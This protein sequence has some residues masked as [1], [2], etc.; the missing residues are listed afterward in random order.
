VKRFFTFCLLVCLLIVMIAGIL[1]IPIIGDIENPSYNEVA[2]Y[3]LENSIADTKSPNAVTAVLKYYRG[4][5]T[6][7]ETGV[8]FTSVVAVISVLRGNK[9]SSKKEGG[10]NG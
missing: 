3:Y 4:A 1:E 2:V 5:D 7:L 9:T 10:N 6:L 8:L